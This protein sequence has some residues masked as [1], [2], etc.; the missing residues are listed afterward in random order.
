MKAVLSYVL[1]RDEDVSSATDHYYDD[2]IIN[3]DKV[4]ADRV[5]K[6]LVEYGLETNPWRRLT[7]QVCSG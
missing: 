7:E 4:C 6:L 2:I 3:L 5:K 1:S